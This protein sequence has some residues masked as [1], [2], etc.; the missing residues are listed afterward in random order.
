VEVLHATEFVRNEG[1]FKKHVVSAEIAG[2]QWCRVRCTY[3]FQIIPPSEFQKGTQ[4]ISTLASVW[5]YQWS[6]WII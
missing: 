1:K 4:S 5:P 2:V 6:R 3:H